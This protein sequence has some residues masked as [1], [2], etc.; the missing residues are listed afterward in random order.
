MGLTDRRFPKIE[1]ASEGAQKFYN[2]IKKENAGMEIRPV[3]PFFISSSDDT[4]IFAFEGTADGGCE[5]YLVNND[6]DRGGVRSHFS[7]DTG[8]TDGFRGLRVKHTVSMTA[9][10]HLAPMH[11]GI[12]GLSDK[13]LSRELCPD[14]VYVMQ[15]KGFCYGGGQDSQNKTIGRVIFMRSGFDTDPK[16]SNDQYYHER[17]RNDVFLPFVEGTRETYLSDKNWT[18]DDTVPDEAA[19]VS[20][21]VSF[22]LHRREFC[23]DT[24]GDTLFCRVRGR[25]RGSRLCGWWGECGRGRSPCNP[26]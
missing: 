11:V 24:G 20:W 6:D 16:I 9:S 4:T 2:L 26:L 1:D 7:D 3:P 8:N 18:K 15:L 13:E 19:F 22:I 10:G 5:T 25:V 17:Y 14:G 12:H 23:R 21:Q